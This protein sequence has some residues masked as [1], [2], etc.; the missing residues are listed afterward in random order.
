MFAKWRG[1]IIAVIMVIL[2]VVFTP[3]PDCAPDCTERLDRMAWEIVQIRAL[4]VEMATEPGCWILAA[5]LVGLAFILRWV[6][7]RKYG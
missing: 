5:L 1:Q 7:D 2:I 6:L 4:W 3:P